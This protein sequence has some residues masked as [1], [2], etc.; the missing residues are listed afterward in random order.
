MDHTI[1]ALVLDDEEW[2]RQLMAGLLKELFP[3]IVVETREQ[4]DS[5]GEFDLYFVDND[6]G[7][8]LLAGKLAREIRA[9]HPEVLIIAFS[10]TLTPFDLKDLI[11]AGCDGVCDKSAPED[12]PTA[13][14]IVKQYLEQIEQSWRRGSG[15][16]LMGAVRSISSLIRSWNERLDEQEQHVQP[17]LPK[18]EGADEQV[19]Q[20]EESR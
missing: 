10:G 12:L 14:A 6:F 2:S 3:A 17:A 15:K 11:N 19:E 5:S 18:G 16:G 8:E 9:S 4:P 1:R 20:S 7:G 13:M